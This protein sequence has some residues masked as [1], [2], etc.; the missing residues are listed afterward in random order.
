[1][2]NLAP[3][4]TVMIPYQKT[5]QNKKTNHCGG[6]QGYLVAFVGSPVQSAVGILKMAAFPQNPYHRLHE[7][8][9]QGFLT[10]FER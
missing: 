1:M 8:F 2:I 4:I 6:K 10:H 5:H 9:L 3:F 7:R